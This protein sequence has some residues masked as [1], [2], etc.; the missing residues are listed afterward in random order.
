MPRLRI[1]Q[2]VALVA[3][4][5]AT[6]LSG[7]QPSVLEA[8]EAPLEVASVLPTLAPTINYFDSLGQETSL[9]ATVSA[10]AVLVTDETSGAVLF[11][12]NHTQP[13]APAS[14]TKLM[15]ALV[16]RDEYQLDENVEIAFTEPVVGTTIGLLD[17][18]SVTVH[19]L[20]EAALISS[21]NDAAEALAAHHLGGKEA[22]IQAM[23]QKAEELGLRHT[24]FANASGLDADGHQMT[25]R[26]VSIVMREV[27]KDQ[28][29]YAILATRQ[30]T[31]FD[32]RRLFSHALYHTHRLIHLD[33]R[34]LAGK[35]GTTEQAGETL[36]T[37]FEIQGHPIAVVIL[38]SEDRYA[39][40]QQLIDWIEATY[41]WVDIA[42]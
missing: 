8:V 39:D 36:A 9:A 33:T 30:T 18:E 35:T 24:S 17:Q 6:L 12:K 4:C 2:Y 25:A 37:L 5:C 19:D 10:A 29:L 15:T 26:D 16:A 13:L 20:L 31:I 22:F 21:G 34:A 41:T 7:G 27:M 32:T 38:G 11:S 3:L 42:P 14:L 40:T 23:N 28:S 1:D